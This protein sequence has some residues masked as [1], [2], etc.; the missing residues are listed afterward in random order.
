[1]PSCP[2]K[3][4]VVPSLLA[5]DFSRL[6]EEIK[7]AEDAGAD[8]LHVDVM[9]GHFVPNITIGPLVVEAIKR[10][11]SVPLDVHLMI[12]D[13]MKYL[14]AFADAG[15]DFLTFH[16]EA[17]KD[18]RAAAQAF[19]KKGVRPGICVS[20]ETPVDGVLDVLDAV[21]QV[22]IMTV[23]PGFGGQEFLEDNVAKIRRVRETEALKRKGAQAPLFI[24]V[25]GGINESTGRVVC[26]AGA[27]VLIAGTF[28]FKSR[29][30]RATL[31]SLRR[32]CTGT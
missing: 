27:D 16:L 11:A 14:G 3:I 6:A 10:A 23:R 24:A 17:V 2:R 26:E 19:R 7:R 9:D 25:D 13:P 21:D 1:M 12:T 22:L 28:L 15:A 5:A 18:A 20:P 32:A 31:S 30:M 29:D 4:E 8:R